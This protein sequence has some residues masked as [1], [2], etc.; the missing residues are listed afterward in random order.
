MAVLLEA[1]GTGGAGETELGSRGG[2]GGEGELEIER[3]RFGVAVPKV[4]VLG[5]GDAVAVVEPP[6]KGARA[7][8]QDLDLAL[9]RDGRRRRGRRGGHGGGVQGGGL[10]L[11]D[12]DRVGMGRGDHL[13]G[14]GSH[15][16]DG[17]R[18]AQAG[19]GLGDVL[20]AEAGGEPGRVGIVSLDHGSRGRATAAGRDCDGDGGVDLGDDLGDIG[21]LGR[22]GPDGGSHGNLGRGDLEPE[23]AAAKVG[24]VLFRAE[25]VEERVVGRAR[26]EASGSGTGDQG[27]GLQEESGIGAFNHFVNE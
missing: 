19:A 26:A 20:A 13:L 18:Q 17:R 22:G 23:E 12:G 9:E 10:G 3:A 8:A 24:R 25:Q 27:C 15:G 21:C 2:A 14:R 16:G 4:V 7:L 1:Q 11:R 6:H 5:D